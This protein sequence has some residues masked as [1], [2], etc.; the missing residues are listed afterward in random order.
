MS[1][2]FGIGA[3]ILKDGNS[4]EFKTGDFLS[5]SFIIAKKLIEFLNGKIKIEE[6]ANKEMSIIFYLMMGIS[7]MN[8]EEN[9]EEEEIE[10]VNHKNKKLILAEDNQINRDFFKAFFMMENY[11]FKIVENGQELVDEFEKGDYRLV[12]TD[13]Q[14]PVMS[15]Y[16]AAKNIR[17]MKKGK[18]IPI[19]GISAFYFDKE[20]PELKKS[21]INEFI[22]KPV[23][24]KNLKEAINKYLN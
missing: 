5:I 13:I 18:N 4:Y 6:G 20:S 3:S 12:L 11:D 24:I 14:M 2:D 1:K 22:S 21:E 8:E 10:E 9:S 16:E 19:V 17:K 7:D 23:S 15:G